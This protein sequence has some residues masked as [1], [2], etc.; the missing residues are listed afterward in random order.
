MA[1]PA[2]SDRALMSF[3][4]MPVRSLQRSAAKRSEGRCKLA[5]GNVG[6]AMLFLGGSWYKV[7]VKGT[8]DAVWMHRLLPQA[9]Y[10]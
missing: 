7:G 10:E 6:P 5:S 3:G 4:G 8:V 1:P 9:V 2:R